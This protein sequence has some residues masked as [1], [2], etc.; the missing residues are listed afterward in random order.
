MLD[1]LKVIL[2]GIVEGITEWLPVSQYRTS[3]SGGECF[4][5]GTQ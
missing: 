5:T 3:D 2:L 1:V 4:K